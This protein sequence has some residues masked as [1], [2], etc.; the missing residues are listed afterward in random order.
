MRNRLLI[1][2]L[3]LL[4][5][6]S[7]L[8]AKP[9]K[10]RRRA[11]IPLPK[12][13]PAPPDNP[14]T[15]A[16]AA[17]GKQLFFDARLSGD[18]KMSCATCHAPEKGF[19]DGRRFAIGANGMKL[20]R[21]TQS[22]WDVGLFRSFFWD[23]RA[24]SLEQQALMPIQSPKE[25]NQPLASLVKELRAVPG[26]RKSFRKVFQRQVS[27]PDIGR[28]LAAYQRTLISRGSAFDRYL[29]GDKKA[30][31]PLAKAGLELFKGDAGCVRCHNGPLLSDSKFYRLGIGRDV[32]L[33]GITKQ[34]KDRYKFRTP[35]LRNI[36]H[37]GPYMHDGSLRTLFDV[38]Q[39]YYRG[40]PTRG[41]E[42]LPLDVESL[43]GQSFS[44]IDA[45]VAFLRTLSGKPQKIKRPVLP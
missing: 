34:R 44:E 32:G 30:L 12:V 5:S 28:A 33:G 26:Y 13:I 29:M 1:A 18:N 6:A 19:S 38:V 21:N 40:V 16:K 24:K 11:L 41:Q 35:S 17:L 3:V 7:A 15:T 10:K 20:T 22:T 39:F 36:A 45:I 2:A 37:T 4:T 31:S 25:M 23:G 9:K 8:G 14:T 43:V 42:G 27:G